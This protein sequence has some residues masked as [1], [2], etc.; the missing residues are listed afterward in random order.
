MAT[1]M[2]AGQREARANARAMAGWTLVETV[3]DAPGDPAWS[4]EQ[5]PMGPGWH[6][7]SRMLRRGLEVIEGA[8]A[9]A[10]PPEWPWRWWLA[11]CAGR[12]A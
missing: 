3:R 7:S 1:S 6:D 4:I 10:L 5:E 2:R 12:A 11:E 9:E 8:P